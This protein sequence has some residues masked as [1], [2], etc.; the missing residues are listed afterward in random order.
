MGTAPL[1]GKLCRRIAADVGEPIK[2]A[3]GSGGY[4]F[5]FVTFDHRHGFWSKRTGEVCWH[6]DPRPRWC[7][8]SCRF[9][10]PEDA[11]HAERVPKYM[12]G[13]TANVVVADRV[14]TAICAERAEHE[15][16]HR[17]GSVSWSTP[18]EVA[19]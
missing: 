8:S 5:G 9:N 19:A 16:R 15:G 3:V 12:C 4:E 6:P 7:W 18:A 14:Y 17:C 10:F 11:D 2:R 13:A 1:G